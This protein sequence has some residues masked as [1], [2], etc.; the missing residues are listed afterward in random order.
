MACGRESASGGAAVTRAERSDV[1]ECRHEHPPRGSRL[2]LTPGNFLERMRE[3]VTLRVG[4]ERQLA[5]ARPPR[6]SCAGSPLAARAATLLRACDAW[7]TPPR[8]AA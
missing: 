6:T 3:N 5:D 7:R 8:A 1:R 4:L 2:A